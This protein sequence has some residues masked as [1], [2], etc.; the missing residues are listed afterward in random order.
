MCNGLLFQSNVQSNKVKK[1]FSEKDIFL[2]KKDKI[3][4]D[5]LTFLAEGIRATDWSGCKNQIKKKCVEYFGG[6]RGSKGD[7]RC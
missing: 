5:N 4:T 6:Y 2:R 1:G 7:G 3:V